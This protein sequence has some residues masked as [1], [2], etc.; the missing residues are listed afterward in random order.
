MLYSPAIA[1]MNTSRDI[2][3]NTLKSKGTVTIA[4]LAEAVGV[5]PVSIRHHLSSLQADGLIAGNEV[6]H[7]VGRPHLAYS[8]TEAGLER[9]PSKYV[10]LSGRL[11]DELKTTLPADA[12]E[13][14]FSRI[15]ETIAA[16]IAP[17]LADK[18]LEE[19]KSLLV[20]LLGEEGFMARWNVVGEKYQLTEYNCPYFRV[21]QK[22]P[23]VCRIDETLISQLLAVPVEKGSCLLNGDEHCTFTITPIQVQI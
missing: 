18:P 9:F 4:E 10:R 13:A 22:H 14:M 21:G 3:L 11:L 7:G 15:A 16:D 17:K 20:E 23:E 2:I 8:L 19:K 5:S 12:I 6:R 1:A